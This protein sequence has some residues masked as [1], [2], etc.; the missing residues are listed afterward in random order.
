[1]F[2]FDIVGQ[3]RHVL[4]NSP[5]PTRLLVR[6]FPWANK[7]DRRV[8][9]LAD[10]QVTG[11][12]PSPVRLAS[13]D[14]ARELRIERGSNNDGIP[15]RAAAQKSN[16][17]TYPSHT[18]LQSA[19]PIRRPESVPTSHQHLHLPPKPKRHHPLPTLPTP[20]SRNRILQPNPPIAL[21]HHRH[22]PSI[23][24]NLLLSTPFPPRPPLLRGPPRGD[25]VGA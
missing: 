14:F 10:Q 11:T 22:H 23:S 12:H 8:V 3:D 20:R 18:S 1:M 2:S 15:S 17:H 9:G 21:K 25:D 5:H 6:T 16:S 24:R 4:F 7:Q 19:R 13:D